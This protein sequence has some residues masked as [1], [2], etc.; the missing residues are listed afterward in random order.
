MT[1]DASWF[2]SHQ[3][4]HN[5]RKNVLKLTIEDATLNEICE[6]F[7]PRLSKN[8]WQYDQK[9]EANTM[10]KIEEFYWKVMSKI[11]PPNH[12]FSL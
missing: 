12:E 7:G 11:R 2:Q 8:G 5:T 10:K 4:L 9:F 3:K 6:H 1:M